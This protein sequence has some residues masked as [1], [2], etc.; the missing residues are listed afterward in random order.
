[1][2]WVANFYLA[3]VSLLSRLIEDAPIQDDQHSWTDAELE[4]LTPAT[5]A[6]LAGPQKPGEVVESDLGT[7]Q[8]SSSSDDLR[9]RPKGPI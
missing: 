3:C 8:A 9:R 4:R 5:R 1:M 7:T 2:V 6:A